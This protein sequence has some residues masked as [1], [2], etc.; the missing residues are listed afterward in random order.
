MGTIKQAIARSN[1]L[2]TV[3]K[4]ITLA[5]AQVAAQGAIDRAESLA[6]KVSVS[7]VDKGGN[8]IVFLCQPGAPLLCSSLAEDKAYTAMCFGM[9]TSEWSGILDSSKSLE[10][11]LPQRN[12][13]VVLGGGLPIKLFKHLVGGI[14]VS[15]GSEE[16]DVECAEAG[17]VALK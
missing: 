10:L 3:S 13:W 5:A 9:S 17:L 8:T 7:I 16:Q 6:I 2:T 1:S 12:R 11:V 15:G 14:G 4:E